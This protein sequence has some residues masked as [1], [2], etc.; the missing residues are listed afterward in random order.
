MGRTS[1]DGTGRQAGLVHACCAC[2]ALHLP[3]Q[4]GPVGRQAQALIGQ[5]NQLARA[6]PAG[7]HVPPAGAALHRLLPAAPGGAHG[8]RERAPG[9]GRRIAAGDQA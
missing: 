7:S 8:G 9:R 1:T 2:R 3:G 5:R 4:R 6:S